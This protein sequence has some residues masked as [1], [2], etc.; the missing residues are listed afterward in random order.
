[1]SNIAANSRRSWIRE[2]GILAGNRR[3]SLSRKVFV[4]NDSEAIRAA[5]E[6]V[7]DLQ[8]AGRDG[9]TLINFAVRQSWQRPESVE[10]VRTLLSLGADPRL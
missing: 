3:C 10:A 5:A 7:P 8:A 1:M 9:T 6:S 4:K 2:D